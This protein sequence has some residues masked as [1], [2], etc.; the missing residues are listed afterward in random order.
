ML[1]SIGIVW[2]AYCVVR[3]GS[4]VLFALARCIRDSR[5]N[6]RDV[7]PPIPFLTRITSVE[8]AAWYGQTGY[9]FD[10]PLSNVL[11]GIEVWH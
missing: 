1:V 9:I 11:L 6:G 10:T 3:Y 5:A 4:C 8:L 7:P 2:L